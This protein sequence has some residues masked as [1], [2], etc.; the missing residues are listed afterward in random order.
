MATLLWYRTDTE[1]QSSFS[2]EV[3]ALVFSGAFCF[4]VF[5]TF[6]EQKEVPAGGLDKGED[7]KDMVYGKIS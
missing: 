4:W 5:F 1:I 6:P 3:A 2:F 7:V